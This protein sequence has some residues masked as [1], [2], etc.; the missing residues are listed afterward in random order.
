MSDRFGRRQVLAAVGTGLTVGLA[1]CGYQPGAG[2]LEWTERVGSGGIPGRSG[3]R[4]WF[5][6]RDRLVAIQN[7]SGRTHDFDAGRWVDVR[8]ARVTVYDAAGE[9]RSVTT[10]AQYDG[11]P[12][13]TTDGIY[14]PLEDGDVT[15]LEWP[16][17][18]EE[19]EADENATR[20]T[21]GRE[22]D[23]L[24]LV[25][26][27]GLVVGVHD[28]GLLAFDAGSGDRLLELSFEERSFDGV[29]DVT[30]AG[31]SIWLSTDGDEPTLSRLD[32]D[33]D[34]RTAHSLPSDPQ[35]LEPVDNG[36]LVGL[37]PAGDGVVWGVDEA[38]ER[39]V[40]LEAG[41]RIR[42]PPIVVD[43][44]LYLASGGELLAVDVASGERAWMLESSFFGEIVADQ[45]GVYGRRRGV[46][47]AECGL[48]AVTTAGEERWA[49]TLPDDVGC[50]GDL[51]LLED[52]LVVVDGGELYGFRREAGRR[53][54]V[55]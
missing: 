47:G 38:G 41:G 19:T 29:T 1:G 55:T 33:G 3:D 52:R 22:G 21:A 53:F 10:D 17:E 36:V 46:G 43:D 12:A 49:A 28:D 51:F 44:R 31:G 2:E 7:R 9:G 45:E 32:A 30:V 15:A 4:R 40:T 18:R 20:W 42:E 27:D 54:T 13:V 50:S 6:A 34:E 39:W 48:V 16:D 5:T 8:D 11:E 35:W 26:G 23:P 25:A 24:E 14:V 37:E